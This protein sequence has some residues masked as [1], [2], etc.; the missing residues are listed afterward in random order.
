V[1]VHLDCI[2]IK[3]TVELDGEAI[4]RDGGLLIS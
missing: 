1:P 2:V 4:V 3:P